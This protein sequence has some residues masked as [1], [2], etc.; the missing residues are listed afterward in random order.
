VWGDRALLGCVALGLALNV[1]LFTWLAW[2]YAGLPGDVA[3]RGRYDPAL[4]AIVADTLRPRAMAWQLPAIG[5]AVVAANGLMAAW[6]HRR[7]RLAALLL[8]ASAV[9]M[10]V[11]IGV[12]LV[13]IG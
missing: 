12:V 9:V 5:L 11:L 7:T 4:D 10:Q 3:L 2:R 6:L 13:Q 1:A 8:V